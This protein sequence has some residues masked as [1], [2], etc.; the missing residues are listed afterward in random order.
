MELK[1]KVV[2]VTGSGR[3]IGAA[4]AL[5]FLNKGCQVILN[6]R[7]EMNAALKTKLDQIGGKYTYPQDK[8]RIEYHH[9]RGFDDCFEHDSNIQFKALL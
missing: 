8:D 1:N 6:G 4:I 7:H 5:G 2:M 9:P 3:G